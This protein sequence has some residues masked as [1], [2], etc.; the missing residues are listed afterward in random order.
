MDVL[1][2]TCNSLSN[3]GGKG[4]ESRTAQTEGWTVG[5]MWKQCACQK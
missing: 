3:N 2:A 4:C 1:S 5:L